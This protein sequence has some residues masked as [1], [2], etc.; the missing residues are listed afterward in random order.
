MGPHLP[1]QIVYATR[2]TVPLPRFVELE[3][4]RGH[5]FQPR[6]CH[7]RRDLSI[8]DVTLIFCQINVE[9]S[10]HNHHAPAGAVSD[11]RDNTLYGRGVIWVHIEPQ[12]KPSPNP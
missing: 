7:I 6:L 10:G 9:I 11:G 3:E 12:N 2:P 8:L 5:V 4:V 1:T